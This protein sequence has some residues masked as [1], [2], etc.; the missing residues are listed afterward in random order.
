[1]AFISIPTSIGGVN[2]PGQ[3]GKIASGP[4]SLLF[5]RPGVSTF[6]YPLDLGTDATKL[7]YVQFSISEVEPAQYG[8]ETSAGTSITFPGAGTT[9][10]ALG[11]E[12]KSISGSAGQLPTS[13]LKD[14][15]NLGISNSTWNTIG[16]GAI[17]GLQGMGTAL[18]GIAGFLNKGFAITPRMTKMKAVI[19]L[20]MPDTIDAA[21][22]AEYDE[23]SLTGDLPLL[24]TIRQIDQIASLTPGFINKIKE[25]KS[26]EAL[27]SVV[28]TDPNVIAL[29][30]KFLKVENVGTLMNKARGYSINPQLQMI[31]KGLDLRNFQ[32]TFTFTPKSAQE[33]RE[34]DSIISTFKIH[35]A[36]RLQAGAQTT[37]ASMYLIPPSMFNVNFMHDGKENIHLP[38]YG[39]CVLVNIDV[40]YT[41]NGFAAYEDGSP[42]QTVMMLQF[43]EVE[44]IDRGKLETG[45]L[46]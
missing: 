3:M 14:P 4:L 43:K 9:L 11:K 21:Y 2:I 12:L 42:V 15:S 24:T 13:V 1:M 39:D 10:E 36:P 29:A 45:A 8:I 37:V 25:G 16:S 18:N 19:S 41:P 46:R 17:T 27:G 22:T 40:N 34:V 26:G 23:M 6:K 7:H 30:S 5:N 28:S 33:A 44:A 31:Y 38:K 35:Y 20:Y 32:L